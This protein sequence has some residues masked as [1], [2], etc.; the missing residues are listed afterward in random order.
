M[1]LDSVWV[2]GADRVSEFQ[3][4]VGD[5]VVVRNHGLVIVSGI[6]KGANTTL[7]EVDYVDGTSYSCHVNQI[8]PV[9][10]K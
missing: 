10:E 7:V 9:E 4:S 3:V 6:E 8:E 1:D 5:K 2:K